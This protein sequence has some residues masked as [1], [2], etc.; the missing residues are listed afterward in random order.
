MGVCAVGAWLVR[1]MWLGVL[2]NKMSYDAIS[3][4]VVPPPRDHRNLHDTSA[5]VD[6]QGCNTSSNGLD[7]FDE[8]LSFE[9]VAAERATRSHSWWT[10][11]TWTIWSVY[12]NSSSGGQ[13]QIRK[14]APVQGWEGHFA[15]SNHSKHPSALTSKA[16]GVVRQKQR[17]SAL[18]HGAGQVDSRRIPPGVIYG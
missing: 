17:P 1:C 12:T 10:G 7:E 9:F 11:G 18:H 6:A 4:N 3:S 16:V 14:H 2:A 13:C 5:R 8:N 15:T